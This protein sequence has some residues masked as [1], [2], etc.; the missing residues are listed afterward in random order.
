MGSACFGGQPTLKVQIYAEQENTKALPP[1]GKPAYPGM[2]LLSQVGVQAGAR[3]K[4]TGHSDLVVPSG[5]CLLYRTSAFLSSKDNKAERTE[6]KDI[7]GSHLWCQRP[8]HRSLLAP[9]PIRQLE[10]R[11]LSITRWRHP[12]L[13]PASGYCL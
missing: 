13:S 2:K 11:G 6:G 3:L 5:R 4:L 8:E 9:K 7:P 10:L 1:S 12:S